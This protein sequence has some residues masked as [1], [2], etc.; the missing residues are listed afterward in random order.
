MRRVLSIVLLA[1]ALGQTARAQ[2]PEAELGASF[3]PI[4]RFLVS[5][6]GPTFAPAQKRRATAA[7]AT[8]ALAEGRVRHRPENATDGK[9]ET[10]WVEGAKGAGIGERLTLSV[11]GLVLGL[12]IVPGFAKSETTFGQNNRVSALTLHFSCR[13]EGSEELA[14]CSD[15]PPLRVRL[16]REGGVVPMKRQYVDLSSEMLDNMDADRVAAIALE[17]REIDAAGARYD[18]TCISEVELLGR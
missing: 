7:V 6:V 8:S 14:P 15:L 16:Q 17:I 2:E 10:A 1:S 13:D 11:S 18:D 9:L 5:P 4:T 12:S 3:E